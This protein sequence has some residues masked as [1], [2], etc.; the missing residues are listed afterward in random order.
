MAWPKKGRAYLKL[1]AAEYLAEPETSQKFQIVE[2][3]IAISQAGTGGGG[4]FLSRGERRAG[5]SEENL[6]GKL[7]SLRRLRQK[8]PT[9]TSAHFMV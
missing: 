8:F 7:L 6:S 5:P 4:N 2:D 9:G 1:P 3:L